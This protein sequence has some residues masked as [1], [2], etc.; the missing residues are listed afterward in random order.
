MPFEEP[1]KKLFRN[2]FLL[3]DSRLKKIL[4]H[5]DA[6]FEIQQGRVQTLW[7]FNLPYFHSW[8]NVFPIVSEVRYPQK[9]K[10]VEAF[11]K[12]PVFF[13]ESLII[14]TM[15][16]SIPTQ[17]NDSG[18]SD[19]KIVNNALQHVCRN[20]LD[21]EFNVVLQSLLCRKIFLVNPVFK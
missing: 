1:P 2:K 5:P 12:Y 6:V 7:S 8:W 10:Q 17:L 9:Y 14:D 20:S 11:E 19:I 18:Y 13:L 3:S 4:L 16:D 21:F 15:V